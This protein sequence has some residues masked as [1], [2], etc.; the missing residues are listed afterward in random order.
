METH[1]AIRTQRKTIEKR[2][3]N[4]NDVGLKKY[5]SLIVYDHKTMQF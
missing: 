3:N 5:N 4:T 1:K 2:Q